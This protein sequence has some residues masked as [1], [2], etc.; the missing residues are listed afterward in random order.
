[1]NL[2]DE[3]LTK[4]EIKALFK[5]KHDKTYYKIMNKSNIKGVKLGGTHRFWKS[6][7]LEYLENK[8]TVVI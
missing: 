2:D 7:I 8:K 4:N 5:I 6:D 1:M 3:L